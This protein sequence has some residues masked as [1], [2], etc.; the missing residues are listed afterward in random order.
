M[1]ETSKGKIPRIGFATLG[2]LLPNPKTGACVSESERFR[3]FVEFG[4]LARA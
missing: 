2:D 1:G 4:V 3:H